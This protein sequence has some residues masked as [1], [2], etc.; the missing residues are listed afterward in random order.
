MPVFDANIGDWQ[1]CSLWIMHLQS[2]RGK[3][4]AS[5]Q[6]C[7]LRVGLPR[8]NHRSGIIKCAVKMPMSIHL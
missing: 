5:Q 6:Q 8:T 4:P 1:A 2:F 7:V 3:V